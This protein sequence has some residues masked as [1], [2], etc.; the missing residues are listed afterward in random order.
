MQYFRLAEA[1]SFFEELDGSMRRKLR[2][3]LWRPRR[4]PRTQAKRL[5]QRGLHRLRR[6]QSAYNGCG[7]GEAWGGD[8]NDAYR[9]GVF[10]QLGLPSLQG[11]HAQPSSCLTSRR[12]GN[13]T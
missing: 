5:M 3:L 10:D 4:R 2:Y 12:I 1:N 13:R 11:L 7:A 6:R 9:A 8:M